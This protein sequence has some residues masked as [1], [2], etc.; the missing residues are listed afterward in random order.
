MST[1]ATYTLIQR[2]EYGTAVNTITRLGRAEAEAMEDLLS[3][4]DAYKGERPWTCEVVRELSAV[5]QA[6]EA[7]KA[8]RESANEGARFHTLTR[9]SHILEVLRG[10]ADDL[11]HLG[12]ME[13]PSALLTVKIQV[14]AGAKGTD[15]DQIKAVSAIAHAL[16]QEAVRYP[17]GEDSTHYGTGHGDLVVVTTAPEPKPIVSD[18]TIRQAEEIG[19]RYPD[20]VT[21]V[22]PCDDCETNG[23]NC[24][25]HSAVTA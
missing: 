21:Y 20:G 7:A 18:E 25:A 3:K 10:I 8:W 17:I 24:Y 11:A 22:E 6:Q 16:G 2:D 13:I 1:S 9:A 5:E 23:R 14:C 12:E 15:Q 4:G 19:K